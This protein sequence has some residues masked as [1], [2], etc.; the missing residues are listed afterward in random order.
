L[1]LFHFSVTAVPQEACRNHDHKVENYR[2]CL[3]SL[4]LLIHYRI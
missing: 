2:N 4:T 1:N 3:T